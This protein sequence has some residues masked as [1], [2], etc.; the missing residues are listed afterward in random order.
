MALTFYT[1][2]VKGL[3]LKVRRF[4]GLIPTLVEVTVE[5][6]EEL[7][8]INLV[9]RLPFWMHFLKFNSLMISSFSSKIKKIV[10]HI[11]CIF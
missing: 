10:D 1:I 11:C 9:L 5:K 3:Q 4:W 7:S 8:L 6:L 2:V